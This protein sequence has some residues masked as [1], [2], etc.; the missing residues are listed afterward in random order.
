MAVVFPNGTVRIREPSVFKTK[1]R[2][3]VHEFPF[4]EQTCILRLGIKKHKNNQL[5]MK[6]SDTMID[7]LNYEANQEWALIDFRGAEEVY[8]PRG[9][10]EKRLDTVVFRVVL[11]RRASLQF[12]YLYYPVLLMNVLAVL[13]FLLPVDSLNKTI[14][15]NHVNLSCAKRYAQKCRCQLAISGFVQRPVCLFYAFRKCHVS[16]YHCV[17]RLHPGTYSERFKLT[18]H[19]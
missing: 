11:R 10:S 17:S 2:I 7:L 5:K 18:S 12:F 13:Q 19:K 8:R 1:C 3:D 15:G 6:T 14:V 4:D 9:S 16:L